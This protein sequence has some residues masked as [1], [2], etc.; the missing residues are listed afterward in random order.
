MARTHAVSCI[1]IWQRVEGVKTELSRYRF[2]DT[3]WNRLAAYFVYSDSKT[4]LMVSATQPYRSR[5]HISRR[6]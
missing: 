5:R 3:F 1:R 4:P 6:A 2:S